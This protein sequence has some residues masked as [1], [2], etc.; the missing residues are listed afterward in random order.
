MLPCGKITGGKLVF[1]GN[2]FRQSP[3]LAI[4]VDGLSRLQRPE[5]DKEVI[6]GMNPQDRGSGQG[7]ASSCPG[8]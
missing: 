3:G 5:R 4:E 6:G 7:H 1:G 2:G 8:T